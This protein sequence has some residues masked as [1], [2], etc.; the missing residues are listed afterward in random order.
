MK[1]VAEALE[2]IMGMKVLLLNDSVGAEVEKACENPTE[3][4]ILLE[5]VRF[6]KEEQNE[7]EKDEK[8]IA[9]R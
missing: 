5:N 7:D 4:L 9:F 2:K 8:V 6:H 3:K 1:P